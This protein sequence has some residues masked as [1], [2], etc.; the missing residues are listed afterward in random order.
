MKPEHL[1]KIDSLLKNDPSL[2]SPA[3]ARKLLTECGLNISAS[4][5]RRLRFKLGWT[6]GRS[7][8]CQLVRWVNENGLSNGNLNPLL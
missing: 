5:V 4:S 7:K 8:Y 3:L 6:C 2:T 1:D